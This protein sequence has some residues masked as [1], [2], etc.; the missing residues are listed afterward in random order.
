MAWAAYKTE[1]KRRNKRKR[2]E[3]ATEQFCY[4][5]KTLNWS[6]FRE[7]RRNVQ[8]YPSILWQWSMGL[9]FLSI[10][11][12]II[13]CTEWF[14]QHR[15]QFYRS[16]TMFV[17]FQLVLDMSLVVIIVF[18]KRETQKNE[19]WAVWF[20]LLLFYHCSSKFRFYIQMCHLVNFI[21]ELKPFAC[22]WIGND[23]M[24]ILRWWKSL[25]VPCWWWCLI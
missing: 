25:D 1:W 21:G 5:L 4:K 11:K 9:C 10:G 14:S 8:I 2:R 13:N 6:T 20:H 23:W 22:V 15:K 24:Y 3:T 19:K 17:F 7:E 12:R 16:N 18:L